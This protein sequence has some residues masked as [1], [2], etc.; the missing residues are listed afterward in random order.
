MPKRDINRYTD[1]VIFP[2]ARESAQRIRWPSEDLRRLAIKYLK[3]EMPDRV[4]LR[5]SGCKR[6]TPGAEPVQ[7]FRCVLTTKSRERRRR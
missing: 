6:V 2:I 1:I 7:K 3:M 5:I 4:L